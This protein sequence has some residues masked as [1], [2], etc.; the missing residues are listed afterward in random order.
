MV[1]WAARAELGMGLCDRALRLTLQVLRNDR[2][3]AEA[4]VVRGQATLLSADFK[5]AAELLKEALRLDPD[6]A[7]AKKLFKSESLHLNRNPSISQSVSQSVR[8]DSRID[9]RIDARIDS[10]S[11]CMNGLHCL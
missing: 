9:S 2:S 7:E 8:S 10:L 6:E 1:L 4:Y 3:C 11:A 5:G